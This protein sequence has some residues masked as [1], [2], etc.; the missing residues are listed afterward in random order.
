MEDVV[1]LYQALKNKNKVVGLSES[2]ALYM[3]ELENKISEKIERLQ[4]IIDRARLR[5]LPVPG[6]IVNQFTQLKV[7][8]FE[9][10][11]VR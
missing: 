3:M 9:D 10:Y 8:L 1:K 4:G 2:E 11:L 7:V 5:G 6:L